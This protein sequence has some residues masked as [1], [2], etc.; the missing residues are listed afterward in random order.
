MATLTKRRSLGS[1][2]YT[3]DSWGLQENNLLQL[4]SHDL[5]AYFSKNFAGLFASGRIAD[6][7][8]SRDVDKV[9]V[10]SVPVTV[11]FAPEQSPAIVKEIDNACVRRS[12]KYMDR[13][14]GG[15]LRVY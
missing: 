5:A 1:A 14:D 3:N 6:R 15:A 9:R 12:R 13:A 4:D 8:T 10:G 11:A 2:N 7:P